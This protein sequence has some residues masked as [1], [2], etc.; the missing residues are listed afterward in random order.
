ME[1]N[2]KN[3]G[4]NWTKIGKKMVIFGISISVKVSF[5]F[6]GFGPE[7]EDF[8]QQPDQIVQIKSFSRLRFV[9]DMTSINI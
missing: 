7:L 5:E 6:E 9:S 3:F 8:S 2:W 1:K 4:K